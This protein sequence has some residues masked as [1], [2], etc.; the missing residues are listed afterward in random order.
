MS[1]LVSGLTGAG[2]TTT[3]KILA[4]TLGWPLIEGSRARASALGLTEIASSSAFWRQDLRANLIDKKRITAQDLDREVDSRLLELARS[5]PPKV[6]DVWFVPWLG[7]DGCLSVLLEASLATRADRV[8]ADLK[9]TQLA[10][11]RLVMRKDLAAAEYAL[12]AYGIDILSDRSKF[13]LIIDTDKVIPDVKAEHILHEA[14][15]QL[16]PQEVLRPKNGLQ[17]RDIAGVTWCRRDSDG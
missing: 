17:L 7:A 12:S 5:K 2:K 6:M 14:A 3:A 10:A 15:F 11:K 13:D 8:A 4:R 16:W 9:L 1:I